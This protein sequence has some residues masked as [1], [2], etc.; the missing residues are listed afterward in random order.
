MT[1]KL[2]EKLNE[3]LKCLLKYPEESWNDSNLLE[4]VI[5]A[6]KH[7]QYQIDDL[8]EQIFDLKNLENKL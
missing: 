5:F 7:Q 2:I 4:E 1:N 8:K 3:H 6:L